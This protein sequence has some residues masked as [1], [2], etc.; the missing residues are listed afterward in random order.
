MA[1]IRKL[2]I[3]S[4]ILFFSLL[5]VWMLYQLATSTGIKND[6]TRKFSSGQIQQ[7][8][9]LDLEYNFFYIAGITN[10]HVFL[11]NEVAP[12]LL[13]KTDHSLSDTSHLKLQVRKEVKFRRAPRLIVNAPYIYFLEGITPMILMGSLNDLKSEVL[14]KNS[15]YFADSEPLSPTSFVLKTYSDKLGKYILTKR[16]TD[17]TLITHSSNLLEKQIDGSFCT[18]GMLHY[19]PAISQLV[20]V[21]FYRN[22]Y[23]GID[24][25]LHLRYRG[26]TI[27]TVSKARIKLAKIN[28]GRTTT[29]AAPPV[30]VNKHSCVSGNLLFIH[31]LLLADNE[32]KLTFE[33]NSVIDVY[34]LEDRTYLFSFYIP[35]I[36]GLKMQDFRV[37]NHTLVAINDRYLHTYHLTF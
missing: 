25:S 10:H 19:D 32:D 13:I 28:K 16:R 34:S 27:D 26:Q 6:F 15:L 5:L 33:R 7:I 4:V 14:M 2:I 8:R 11:G 23:I 30:I 29:M 21:Y 36:K 35:K 12:A 31:S 37:F 17:T 24:T 18:D 1:T 20:Y 22:Q 3:P 9:V